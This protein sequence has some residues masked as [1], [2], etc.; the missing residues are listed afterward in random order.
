MS[1]AGNIIIKGGV[2]P[3][4]HELRTAE[5]LVA[6]GL[7][8]SFLSEKKASTKARQTWKSTGLNGR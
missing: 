7:T 5:A 6:H 2:K 1:E 8:V 4:P 3:W